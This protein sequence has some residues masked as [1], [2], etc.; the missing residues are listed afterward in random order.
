MKNTSA[1]KVHVIAFDIPFPPN[2]G[3]VIDVY[4]KIEM[5]AKHGVGVILHVFE[6]PGRERAKELEDLCI[7]VFYY[8]RRLGFWHLFS[9]IPYIVLT[10][11]S[12]H[13]INNLLKDD[14]PVLFEGLHTTWYLNDKRLR[15]RKKIFRAHNV[16]HHYYYNLFRVEKNLPK[17]LFYLFE[18][19]KLKFYERRLKWAD[20]ICTV[21]QMDQQYF[22]EHLPQTQTLYLPSFHKNNKVDILTGSGDYV[23]YNGNLEVAEND[24]AIQYVIKEIFNDLPFRLVIAGMNPLPHLKSL[25]DPYSNIQLI[26]NPDESEMSRLIREA[27]V[28]LLLTFQATGLK[29]KLLNVLFRGRHCLVN[30]PM[31]SGTGLDK[32]CEIADDPIQIKNAI[33]ALFEKPF[34]LA[35]IELRRNSLNGIYSNETRIKKLIEVL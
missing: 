23:L 21:S 31:L 1:K 26:E 34:T 30:S 27:H 16:E 13:L 9:C 22:Q 7:D 18:S 12:K 28:H 20:T 29:L 25:I 8:P 33:K 15:N 6:Y 17:R 24:H 4:Y 3:G 5:L 35:D 2:Y 14:H 11:K 10:R 19:C 32:L